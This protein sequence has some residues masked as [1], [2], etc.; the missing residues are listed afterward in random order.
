MCDRP[1]LPSTH[2]A[3]QPERWPEWE[4]PALCPT[5]YYLPSAAT[6]RTLNVLPAVIGAGALRLRIGRR[7]VIYFSNKPSTESISLLETKLGPVQLPMLRAK[8]CMNI[9]ATASNSVQAT[10]ATIFP[11]V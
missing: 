10:R 9:P 1:P 7:R 2:N 11:A 5:T 4:R 3:A 8:S 6:G